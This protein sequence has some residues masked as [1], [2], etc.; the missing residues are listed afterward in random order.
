MSDHDRGGIDELG[1]VLVARESVEGLLQRVA[2][3]ALQVI[4]RCDSASV[5]LVSRLVVSC[6]SWGA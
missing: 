5:S 2:D 1:R 6:P 3:T 4:N